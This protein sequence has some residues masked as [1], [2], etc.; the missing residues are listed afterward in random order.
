MC[1]GLR[2]LCNKT[3][4]PGP[5]QT[6]KFT[7]KFENFKI[8]WVSEIQTSID[9]RH[10][11]IV[12]FLNS[13]DFRHFCEMSEIRTNIWFSDTKGCWKSKVTNVEISDKFRLTKFTGQWN[14]E[15]GT[16]NNRTM[17]KAELSIVRTD[18][19]HIFDIWTCSTIGFRHSTVETSQNVRNPKFQTVL[20]GFRTQTF[21]R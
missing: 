18:W 2:L 9:F 7:S 3:P 4:E 16:S 5:W 17:L 13:W 1:W 8:Q 6:R 10:S 11:I 15:I 12:W 14:A 19:V 20:I 21:V